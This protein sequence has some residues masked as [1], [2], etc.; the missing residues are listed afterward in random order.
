MVKRQQKLS[1]RREF[2][3]GGVVFRRKKGAVLWLVGKH[4]G[5]HKWVLPKGLI[6]KGERGFETA[7]REVEEEMGVKVRLVSEKPI[8][9]TQYVYWA[10]LKQVKSSLR[11]GPEAK[12]K[13][14]NKIS[15]YRQSDEFKDKRRVKKYQESGGRKTKVFKVVSFYLMEYESGDVAD[16]D[17]EMEEAVWLPY[18]EAMERLAFEGEREALAKAR[19]TI[20]S[21]LEA[22]S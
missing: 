6:E 15:N 11:A 22:R 16:H 4:S 2:S 21:K 3:A 5:Y 19:D 18:E 7:V 10:D 14:K 8:H 12:L 13:V 17:W 20:P 1:I 9:R